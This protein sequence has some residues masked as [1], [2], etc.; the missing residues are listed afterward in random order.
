MD[1]LALIES[2]L[3]AVNTEITADAERAEHQRDAISKLERDGQ[4][5]EAA[6]ERLAAIEAS[7]TSHLAE[8][9]GLLVQRSKA[10]RKS[11]LL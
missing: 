5:S 11:S 10:L 4:N 9:L 1:E 2:R 6:R 8:R 3:Q 7:L